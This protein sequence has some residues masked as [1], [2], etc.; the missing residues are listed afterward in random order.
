VLFVAIGYIVGERSGTRIPVIEGLPMPCSEDQLKA[1]GAVAASSGAV[2][3]F[4]AIRITPEASS[5]NDAF[6]G[7]APEEIIDL[8]ISD[9]RAALNKL[10]T[11]REG[12]PISAISLGTPH[13]S[14]QEFHTL[15]PLLTGFKLAPDVEAYINTS[16]E[17][18]NLIA[19]EGTLEIVQRGGIQ[20]VTDTCTYITSIIRNLKGC[21]MTNSG[22]WAHYAPG[23]LG[24]N[25]AFGSTEDCLRSAS[26]GKVCIR[27]I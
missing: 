3:M 17:T 9:V 27:P 5:L 11:A 19:E 22:K 7:R 25:V 26:E 24:V 15:L 10:S 12:T 23:N 16:R 20:V 6:G 8:E 21:V 18:Y 2:A 13:F 1:L 4:H 14:Y